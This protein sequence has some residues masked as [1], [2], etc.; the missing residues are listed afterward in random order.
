M[1]HTAETMGLAKYRFNCISFSM[2]SL[3]CCFLASWKRVSGFCKAYL[4]LN[5]FNIRLLF[6]EPYMVILQARQPLGVFWMCLDLS[7]CYR[8]TH[9]DILPEITHLHFLIANSSG[10]SNFTAIHLVALRVNCSFSWYWFCSFNTHL[11]SHL[12]LLPPVF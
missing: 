1:Y 10:S 2:K 5:S 4:A 9:T 3:Y 7:Y 11:Q 8:A 12:V 6:P